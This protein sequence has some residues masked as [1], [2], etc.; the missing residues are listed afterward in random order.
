VGAD[1]S[2][3]RSVKANRRGQFRFAFPVD[4]GAT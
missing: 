4:F 1:G 3:E 2:V